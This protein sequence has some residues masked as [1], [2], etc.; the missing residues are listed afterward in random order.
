VFYSGNA[1]G[2][3]PAAD[4]EDNVK[5][6]QRTENGVTTTVTQK[7]G[8]DE[9]N[10]AM[11]GGR[12]AVKKMSSITWTDYAITY[13]D[14]RDVRLVLTEVTKD[15]VLTPATEAEAVALR[16][17]RQAERRAIA[18][19]VLASRG[20]DASDAAADRLISYVDRYSVG[21]E[22]IAQ[23][24]SA[25]VEATEA[26][27]EEPETALLYRRQDGNHVY[28]PVVVV[29][30]KR[31]VIDGTWSRGERVN[32]FSVRNGERFGPVRDA[33]PTAK[34]GSVGRA[35]VDAAERIAAGE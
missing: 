34:P 8:M 28:G 24:V 6:Y 29:K 12:R 13:K 23:M 10:H 2:E 32:Y 16:A 1:N 11:M 21:R 26:P 19:Q 20:H 9:I 30:G 33:F 4:E 22:V 31:Y 15:V 18:S 17:E 5:V 7:T 35:I 25:P 14:G 27:A 3:G